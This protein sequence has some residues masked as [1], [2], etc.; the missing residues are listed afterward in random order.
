M[1]AETSGTPHL[2]VL[3]PESDRGRRISLNKD[4]QVVGREPTGDVRFD[5]PC[6][7]RAH[8]AAP[9]RERVVQGDDHRGAVGKATRGRRCRRTPRAGVS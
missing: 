8:A 6:V 4:Y 9:A 3:A 7:S 2:T 5:D 1:R